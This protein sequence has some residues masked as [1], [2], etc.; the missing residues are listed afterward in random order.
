MFIPDPVHSRSI[1]SIALLRAATGAAAAAGEAMIAC[2]C[3]RE[4]VCER[5]VE[6][7][8]AVYGCHGQTTTINSRG[9][10]IYALKTSLFAMRANLRSAH[11]RLP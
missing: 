4:R 5:T 3:V 2:V 6:I 7:V 1:T 8:C 11:T 9:T 10:T